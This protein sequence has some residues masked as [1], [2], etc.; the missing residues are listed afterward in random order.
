[1]AKLYS[2]EDLARFNL[3]ISNLNQTITLQSHQ[4]KETVL[5]AHYSR[6][7]LERLFFSKGFQGSSQE[8][9]KLGKTLRML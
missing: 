5:E 7:E 4:E 1:M 6:K 3:I 2:L 8:L 9:K